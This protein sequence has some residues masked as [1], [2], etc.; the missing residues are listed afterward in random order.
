MNVGSPERTHQGEGHSQLADLEAKDLRFLRSVSHNLRT[1]LTAVLGFAELLQSDAG[2]MSEAERAEMVAT[3]AR[4]AVVI[5]DVVEDLLVGALA[6]SGI[7]RVSR[8]PVNLGAQLAQVV[9]RTRTDTRVALQI[10]GTATALADP[11]HVRQIIRHSFLNAEIRNEPNILVR[12]SDY[13]DSALLKVIS[14]GPGIPIEDQQRVFEP[15]DVTR[16]DEAQPDLLGLGLSV[17]RQLARLMDGNLSYRHGN[18]K[19]TITLSL[20]AH[21]AT[22]NA[23]NAGSGAS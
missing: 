3:I 14:D 5:S 20:P 2:A 17:A 15:F 1:P 19:S 16:R 7:L 22:G 13:E 4:Q 6:E 10:D 11:G 9:E 12:L 18:E 23:V 8:V 21:H